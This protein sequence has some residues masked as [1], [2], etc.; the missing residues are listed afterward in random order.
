MFWKYLWKK[1]SIVKGV[2]QE[3]NLHKRCRQANQWIKNFV[4]MTSILLLM[5]YVWYTRK[6]IYWTDMQVFSEHVLLCECECFPTLYMLWYISNTR[7]VM[8][9]S[10]GR[11]SSWKKFIGVGQAKYW[12]RNSS[13][14]AHLKSVLAGAVRKYESCSAGEKVLGTG[15]FFPPVNK[16]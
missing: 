9:K 10:L 6:H 1:F 2:V 4:Q 8:F 12:K 5:L 11:R 7:L 16:T 15:P 3:H 13:P 14:I